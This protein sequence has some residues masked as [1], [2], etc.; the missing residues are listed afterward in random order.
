MLMGPVFLLAA[1]HTFFVASPLDV[2]AAPWSYMLSFRSLVFSLG[3]S[4]PP[5]GHRHSS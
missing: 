3:E 1:Y 2:G 4:D 5:K